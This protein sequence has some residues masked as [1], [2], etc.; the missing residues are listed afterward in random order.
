VATGDVWRVIM[1]MRWGTI[2]C[3]P[4]FH[5]IEGAGGPEPVESQNVANAVQTAM[6]TAAFAGFSDQLTFYAIEVHDAQPGTKPSVVYP[7][8]PILGDIADTNPLPPQSAAVISLH[9][10]IKPIVG[11]FAATGRI[12]LPGIPQVGQISGFLEVGFQNS[13]INWAENLFAAFVEDATAYQLFVVSYLPGS[14]PQ[15]V[16]ATN[17]VT[18]FTINN[19]V[20]SQRR[21][22]FGVGI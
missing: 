5:L 7:I 17:A 2:E 19:V 20:R 6:S 1:H 16:R 14:K 10:D 15:T 4:G 18:S 22:Q 8:T 9:T 21:R 11:A 12:Y 13:L 3:R